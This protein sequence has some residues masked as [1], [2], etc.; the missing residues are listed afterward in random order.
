[1][2]F[3]AI[4]LFKKLSKLIV[5]DYRELKFPVLRFYEHPELPTLVLVAG[6][7]DLQF[8]RRYAPV[9]DTPVPGSLGERLIRGRERYRWL[10][11]DIA[12][13][14]CIIWLE[15]PLPSAFAVSRASR[16]AV[17]IISC[18]IRARIMRWSVMIR[19]Q[20]SQLTPGIF[21]FFALP[22]TPITCSPPADAVPVLVGD[23]RMG[24]E[25]E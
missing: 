5:P 2:D 13:I 12:D 20:V 18:V 6:D 14:W 19:L 4:D 10:Y 1:M 7:A 15:N 21:I 3:I 16:T 25:V 22:I 24:E 11:R 9:P 17:L 8:Y 23:G